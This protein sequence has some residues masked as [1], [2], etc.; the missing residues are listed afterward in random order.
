[1]NIAICDDESRVR[2]SIHTVLGKAFPEMIIREFASGRELLETIGE[3]YMP[4]IVLLDIAMDGM[5]GMETAKK[6]RELSD[7]LLIFVTGIKEQVFQAFDVGAFHYLLKPVE[8]EKLLSVMERAIAEVEKA[9]SRQR[10]MLVKAADGY[11]RLNLSDILYAESDGRKVI[12]HTK[13]EK[14]EFYEKMEE[15]EK[16]LGEGFYRCHRS[17]IVSLAEIRGYD[18]TSIRVSNGEQIYLAKRKYGEFVQ[19]YCGFLQESI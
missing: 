2:E 8:K 6:L 18:S 12:L 16:R 5:D 10:Y 9:N 11:R 13:Q 15:L 17:Y 7:M 14:L 4:D 19:T 1:M 3:T